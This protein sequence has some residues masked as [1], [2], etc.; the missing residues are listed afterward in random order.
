MKIVLYD[1]V[2]LLIIVLGKY[3]FKKY[4]YPLSF[5]CAALSDSLETTKWNWKEE[6]LIL[7]S[8]LG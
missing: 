6:I 3:S 1:H 5:A 2:T 7:S 4:D 8:F